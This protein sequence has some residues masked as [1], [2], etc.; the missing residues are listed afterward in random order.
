MAVAIVSRAVWNARTP[1]GRRQ[2]AIPT[3]RLWIHHSADSARGAAGMRSIQNFHMD[4]RGYADIGYSFVVDNA[5]GKIF[6]GR[7]VGIQGAHTLGDNT[8]SHAICVMGNFE[9]V[10]PSAQAIASIVALARHGREKGWW[11]PTCRGHREAPMASTACPGAHL[12]AR[13]GEIRTQVGGAGIAAA[14]PTPE[15][16][17]VTEEELRP[18]LR[19]EV[20]KVLNQQ[21][22]KVFGVESWENY[23]E[24]VLKAA[25]QH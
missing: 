13:L 15:E 14:L 12:F 21:A 16:A 22:R 5:D 9:N 1:E 6:E 23:L 17:D 4:T 24:A 18:I 25:R 19:E 8:K 11:A 3:A 10:Q 20:T 7:G 2:I